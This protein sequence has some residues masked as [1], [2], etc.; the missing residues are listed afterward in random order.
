MEHIKYKH[1]L[2]L[3]GPQSSG[4]AFSRYSKR[5]TIFIVDISFESSCVK[6]IQNMIHKM[7]DYI[8]CV[9]WNCCLV[10]MLRIKSSSHFILAFSLVSHQ[11]FYNCNCRNTDNWLWITDQSNFL[12]FPRNTI[13][14]YGIFFSSTDNRKI[15]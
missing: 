3:W 1:M 13:D 12:S 2:T 6:M 7:I 15:T 14:F 10:K 9:Y 5:R 8:V 4:L 11:K